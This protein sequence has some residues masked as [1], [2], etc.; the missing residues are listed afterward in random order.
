[1]SLPSLHWATDT[2][3]HRLAFLRCALPF[4][5]LTLQPCSML[6][7]S[8]VPGRAQAQH[9]R[10]S[11]PLSLLE[12]PCPRHPRTLC[13]P[14]TEAAHPQPAPEPGSRNKQRLSCGRLSSCSSRAQ[15]ETGRPRLPP[16]S[17][18]SAHNK[19]PF[20]SRKEAPKSEPPKGDEL[21]LCHG[22]GRSFPGAL[23][24]RG[25]SWWW[26]SQLARPFTLEQEVHRGLACGVSKKRSKT[27]KT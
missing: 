24:T 7:S 15:G 22:G 10:L 9:F 27:V 19:Q 20:A 13:T 11:I 23:P 5:Q 18:T 8:R 3:F 26:P 25:Y 14:S 16:C 21:F 4:F 2:Q 17:W 6:S 12:I 1:M